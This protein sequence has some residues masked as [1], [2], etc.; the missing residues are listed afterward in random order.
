[1]DMKRFIEGENR[2]QSTLFP[3]ALD[4]YIAEENPVRVIDAFVTALDFKA[5]G[6][7][8]IEPSVTGAPAYHPAALLKIYIYGYLNRIQSSR[9]LEKEARRNVE[10]MWLTERLS[11]SFKTIA[12]FRKDNGKGII[13]VCK[14]FVGI[15][16]TL[17]LFANT[18]VAIDGSKFKAVNSGDKNFTPVRMKRRMERVEKHIARYLAELEE[19]DQA[20][21]P[22]KKDDTDGIKKKLARMQRE[23]QRLN[24]IDSEMMN[25]PDKQISLTD[26]DA[27]SMA[28]TRRNSGA[29]C[30][31]V[32]TA[33]DTTHHLIV[34]HEVT[35]R[36]TDR[37]ELFNMSKLARTEMGS[38]DLTVLADRGY[39]SG[40]EI[41]ACQRADIDV[42]VPKPLTSGSKAAG[43]FTKQDFYYESEHNQYRC[44]AGEALKWRFTIEE[45]GKTMHKYWSSNCQACT[46]QKQ[47]TT[48]KYRRISRWEHEGIIDAMEAG[49][50]KEPNKMGIRRQTVEHPYGTLKHWMGSTHFLTKRFKGVSTEMSLHVL[51]Y[52]LKRVMKIIGIKPLMEAVQA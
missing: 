3:E 13:N 25:H 24:I 28:S 14:E 51:A 23:M 11:P 50:E 52:N 12:D 21:P 34:A 27:R 49:L 31:N 35:N 33:V 29:V 7:K 10:M 39:L 1:M 4:D 6:F 36:V 41:L 16:R 9:R 19:A 38:K 45:K 2:S 17:N 26:P 47:C 48:G 46:I 40:L 18:I 43:R 44:P 20:T 22:P 30:Y 8:R 5:L 15:C 32:Q 42:Y 37:K